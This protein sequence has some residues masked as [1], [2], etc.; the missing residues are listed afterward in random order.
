MII[1]QNSSS[2]SEKNR[3][4]ACY[5]AE[6]WF[7]Y[8]VSLQ[9]CVFA[10]VVIGWMLYNVTCVGLL[11]NHGRFLRGS[12]SADPGMCQDARITLRPIVLRY[13][14]DRAHVRAGGVTTPPS[15]CSLW[16]PHLPFANHNL[17]KDRKRFFSRRLPLSMPCSILLHY[18]L[19]LAF[20]STA[21]SYKLVQWIMC[22]G[23][24]NALVCK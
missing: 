11:L 24:T 7:I 18:P 13:I 4:W 12:P 3:S 21:T 6:P 8:V 9:A 23:P 16:L 5:R 2:Y 14:I 20:G 1:Y 15:S 19:P 10:D 17:A 22:N